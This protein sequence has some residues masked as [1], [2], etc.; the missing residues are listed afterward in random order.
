MGGPLEI[1]GTINF[2]SPRGGTLECHNDRARCP[3]LASAFANV[4]GAR[5]S[6][7]GHRHDTSEHL[8][9]PHHH[10]TQSS[11]LLVNEVHIMIAAHPD[12]A[13]SSLAALP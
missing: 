9:R 8:A 1:A 12:R 6:Y 11:S 10:T 2:V 4:S 7:L 3:V 13:I 5:A